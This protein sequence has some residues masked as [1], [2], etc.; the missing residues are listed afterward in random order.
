LRRAARAETPLGKQTSGYLS[1]GDLVPDDVMVKL[2]AERLQEP[3]CRAG[4]I[5]DGS[6][7][8]SRRRTTWRE[9]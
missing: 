4:F 5:L 1:S 3:D 6:R 9:F 8:R 7:A 2:V